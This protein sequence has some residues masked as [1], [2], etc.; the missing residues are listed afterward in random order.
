MIKVLQLIDGG[1]IGGG[2]THIIS[3]CRNLD[4]NNFSPV[5]S[6]D[7][8]GDFSILVKKNR[9]E[10]R[11]IKLPKIFRKKYLN[12]LSGFVRE[13]NPDIIHA[14][15]G[16]AG[17]Y[18]RFLKRDNPELKIVYTLHG[19][20]YLMSKNL[21]RKYTSLAIEQYLVNFCDAYI[22]V[23]E[24][25]VKTAGKNKIISSDKVYLI[26]NGININRFKNV[27]AD[28]NIKASLGISENDFVIGNVS[29][30]DEQK[31]QIYIIN[32]MP[33]LLKQIPDLKLLLIGDGKLYDY[34][35]DKADKLKVSDNI[36]FAGSVPDPE[37]YYP[38]MDLFVFPSK[39]EGFSITL[40]EAL[41]SGRCIIASDIPS[42]REII[43]HGESGMLFKLGSD[44]ALIKQIL[45]LY[46]NTDLK[47]SLSDSA[48]KSSEIYDE[49]SMTEKISNIYLSL[50]K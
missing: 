38:L 19:I 48:L 28:K 27:I 26:H 23:S 32:K 24:D 16:V 3:L 36:I 1:F 35:R 37:N 15:G 44:K 18:S 20:H 34:C 9:L 41:A 50:L 31:N 40:L 39:W 6:A 46:G 43:R 12:A 11:G 13:M 30:F 33:E 21:I 22:C 17:M 2:Q 7:P 49:K 4:K 47:K 14:H 42:N 10:F 29:R 5:I 25:D 8:D 45:E